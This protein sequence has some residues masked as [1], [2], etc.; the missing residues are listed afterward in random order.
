MLLIFQIA[1]Y[2]LLF[3]AMVKILAQDSGL[4]CLY[5][6]PQD[7]IDEAARRGLAD[8]DAVMKK[9]KLIMIPFCVILLAVLV[10]ILAVWNRAADFKTAFRQAYLFLLVMNWFDGILLDLV[11]VSRSSLWRIKGMEGVPYVKPLK[12]VLI[13]RGAATVLYLP[14]AAVVAVLVV[15]VAKI[16]A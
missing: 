8:R 2:C 4:N 14:I 6:Y 12:T 13:K 3:I 11:W 7:Y 16:W 10:L 1:L 5:F 15:A 9:G